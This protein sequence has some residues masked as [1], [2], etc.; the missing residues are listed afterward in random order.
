MNNALILNLPIPIIRG[1]TLKL[2]FSLK[3]FW[4][5]SFVLIISLLIF[6][7]F[8]VNALTVETYQIH[9]FQKKIST[10]LK[11]N[12][13]LR[14]SSAKLNSSSNLETLIKDFGFEKTE[15]IHYIQILGGQVATN[16]VRK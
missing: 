4:I 2:R 16:P 13:S 12:E 9:N 10:I 15:K 5:L 14:I 1:L 7:I 8:Q 6:Y 11:E 3:I